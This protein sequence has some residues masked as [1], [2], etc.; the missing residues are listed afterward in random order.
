M[1]GIESSRP[2][3]S[4]IWRR[5]FSISGASR[6]RMPTFIRIIGSLAYS[7]YM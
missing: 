5:P 4:S 2:F 1:P 7:R 6:R 3:S